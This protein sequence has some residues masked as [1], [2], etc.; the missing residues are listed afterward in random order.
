MLPSDTLLVSDTGH[1]G[2]WTGTMIDL[3]HAG[4]DYIRCAGSLG[5]AFPA[6]LGAKCALPDRPI[7]CFTGDGGFWYHIA[8]I[9]TAV[10]WG[11]NTVT[12]VNNNRSLN[13]GKSGT[14][15]DYAGHIGDSDQ[16]WKFMD[17]DFA[18]MA[19][20]LGCFAV[21]V[22]QPSEF[23]DALNQALESGKP[24]VVDVVSDVEA[25]APLPWG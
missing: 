17:V 12:V 11:I 23:G 8:E 7:V 22:T 4:Q 16:L 10:R 1:A 3:N 18:E 15:R 2:I 5:W 20:Y 24:A 9:E 6:A 21:R 14:E 13:Q 19:R 25:I